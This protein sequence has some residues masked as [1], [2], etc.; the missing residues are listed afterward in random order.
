[1]IP[2]LLISLFATLLVE[3][4]VGAVLGLRRR[5]EVAVAVLMNVVTN[6]PVVFAITLCRKFWPALAFPVVFACEL[7]AVLCEYALLRHCLGLDRKRAALISA[8]LNSCS[9][10]LGLFI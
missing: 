1:M 10:C 8:A 9:L 2:I 4:P 5:G 3:V 7:L 6:P